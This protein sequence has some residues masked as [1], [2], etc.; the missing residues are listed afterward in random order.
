MQVNYIYINEL[1]LKE[2]YCSCFFCFYEMLRLKLDFQ[3]LS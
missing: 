2:Y 1:V 3:R